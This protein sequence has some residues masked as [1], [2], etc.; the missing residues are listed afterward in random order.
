METAPEP[1]ARRVRRLPLDLDV[2][3]AGLAGIDHLAADLVLPEGADTGPLVVCL[4]G[5]GMNRR[6]FD[7]P[8]ADTADR[9]GPWSMAG[10]L[11]ERFG[12]AVA[13]VDHPAVGDSPVPADPWK[14]VP[15]VV[16]DVDDAAVQS[17]LVRLAIEGTWRPTSVVGCGHS[18]GGMLTTRLQQRHRRFDALV[19]L[20]FGGA[21]LPQYLT[22]ADLA[23]VGDLA[24][25]EPALPDLVRERFGGP[26]RASTTTDSELLA[27]DVAPGARDVLATAAA[28]LLTM[29]GLTSMIP[30][31]S[32]DAMRVIDVPVFIGVG[33]NDIAG[34][35]DPIAASFTESPAVRAFTLPGAGHNH[36]I[37]RNRTDLWDAIGEWI[38]APRP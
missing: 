11:A 18:M 5:G 7:L 29:C 8:D 34:A 17:L 25:L 35:V 19:L 38:V 3:A 20:G 30:G 4:P 15:T 24:G 33:D 21:G 10:H 27:P 2:T 28:D 26:L 23:H 13:V 22:S 12:I 36:S 31:T 37:S 14:L 1:Y 16:A 32:D 6:Y 9:P